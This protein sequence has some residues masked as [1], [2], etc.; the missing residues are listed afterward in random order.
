M[1]QKVCLFLPTNGRL[2][3]TCRLRGSV[4]HAQKAV[5]SG[6]MARG[7]FSYPRPIPVLQH[8]KRFASTFSFSWNLSPS[9][10]CLMITPHVYFKIETG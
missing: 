1:G 6:E 3:V 8:L 2:L 10:F 7:N 9:H 4:C 5:L